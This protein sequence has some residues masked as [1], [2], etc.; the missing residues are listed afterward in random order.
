[1]TRTFDPRAEPSRRTEHERAAV[2][3]AEYPRQAVVA[4]DQVHEVVVGRAREI[5]P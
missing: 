5:R 2:V 3:P 4:E 1:M